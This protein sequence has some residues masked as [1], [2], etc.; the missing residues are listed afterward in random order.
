MNFYEIP[1]V[2]DSEI[3]GLEDSLARLKA[4]ELTAGQLKIHRVPFGVYE[5]RKDGAY[6]VRIR[7][8]AG[9]I[10]PTQFKKAAELSK[11]YGNPSIH[12]TTRQEIQ[13]HDVNI[14]KII[15]IIR[16]LREVDISSRGGGGNTV[17]NVMA[18]FDSGLF[19]DDVFDVTTYAYELTN[20]LIADKE[21]WNLP[22]KYKITFSSKKNN[23]ANA[24]VQ[25]LGFIADI[26]DGVKGFKVYATGGM[27]GGPELGI[28]LHEFAPAEDIYII[29]EALKRVFSQYGNRKNKHKARLRW[30]IKDLGEEK[31]RE[32]YNTE[33]EELRAEGNLLTFNEDLF[34]NSS[35]VSDTAPEPIIN[36]S[37]DYKKW[38]GRHVKAQT[39]DGLFA[40]SIPL[41]LGDIGSDEAG[42]LA[43]LLEKLGDNTLRFT[44]DQNICLRNIPE[45][46]LA[47]IY[48]VA[49]KVSELSSKSSILGNSVACTGADTCRLGICLPKGLNKAIMT[50]LEKGRVDLDRLAAVKINI[51]G[52]PNTC[53]QHMIADIGFSGKVGRNGQ[54]SYPAYN[55][56]AG[57]RSLEG[58]ER[59]AGIITDINARDLPDFLE[60]V[61]FDFQSKEDKYPTFAD[62]VDG[63]DKIKDL[64]DN[65]RDVPTFEE[66][67]NYYF[68]WGAAEIFSLV[69]RGQGECSA[70]LFDLI[71]FDLEQSDY[72]IKEYN[73]KSNVTG[74][75]VYRLFIHVAR[76]LLITK[77]IE[78]PTEKDIINS[79]IKHF[80]GEGH[81]IDSYKDLVDLGTAKDLNELVKHYI[82]VKRLLKSV[83]DLY[84]SMDN[85]LKFPKSKTIKEKTVAVSDVEPSLNVHKKDLRGVACPMNFVK[86]KIEL[87]QINA[88]DLLEI[89]LDD[90]EPIANVPGSVEGEGHRVLS[91]DR[92]ADYWKV[93]IE[94]AK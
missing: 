71:D 90:G 87:S 30:L 16:G 73:E 21:S 92:I 81:I 68:D 55:I 26:R 25:D 80:I 75:D 66:D 67:K 88:G 42:E 74:E 36:N 86:T 51:S 7:C 69:G 91:Q 22:R 83:K 43:E 48:E 3:D 60:E 40:V 41:L 78:A 47:N 54:N 19:Y 31:L 77:G 35:N 34:P 85:S 94:K 29:A 57:A 11:I 62:Y 53:G 76:A 72:L 13:I 33:V 27:G 45:V 12:V 63:E 20:R 23:N 17:R 52:C 82:D 49:V 14:D 4:G 2:L 44:M 32:L 24:H 18:S 50:R 79:F 15:P 6:M 93:I 84:Q 5:Q 59:L 28:I 10:T 70:G 46:Y 1:N 58:Q 56:V 89:L 9:A 8:N 64:A 65:Y 39:Q 38:I 61:L 37:G